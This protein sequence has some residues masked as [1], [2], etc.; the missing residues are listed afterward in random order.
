MSLCHLN[1]FVNCGE[2][3]LFSIL[4]CV[5]VKDARVLG[6]ASSRTALAVLD[7]VTNVYQRQCATAPWHLT[8][9]LYNRS[10]FVADPLVHVT[11]SRLSFVSRLSRACRACGRTTQRRVQGKHLL[12]AKCTRNK[13][14]RYAWMVP[15]RVAVKC[16]AHHIC[17]HKGPRGPLVFAH[18][19]LRH[20]KRTTR[21]G[22]IRMC[23][24]HGV[25]HL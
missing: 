6:E 10:V 2:D 5:M 21:L 25:G 22:L 8:F 24:G 9:P 14:L 16:G 17:F 13:K 15:A 1:P 11:F 7:C 19:V 3:I 18:D 4:Q 12:C 23:T 20:A